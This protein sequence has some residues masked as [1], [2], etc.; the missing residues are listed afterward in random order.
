MSFSKSVVIVNLMT[1]YFVTFGG[2]ALKVLPNKIRHLPKKEK[3]QQVIY[4]MTRGS[5]RESKLG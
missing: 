1:S 4:S 2:G 3:M 5:D